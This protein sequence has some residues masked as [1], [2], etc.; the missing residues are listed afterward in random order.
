MLLGFSIIVLWLIMRTSRHI[1]STV[2]SRWIPASI[3]FIPLE[4]K[5]F[6][7]A[8]TQIRIDDSSSSKFIDGSLQELWPRSLDFLSWL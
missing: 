4:F 1:T 2:K 6:K 5:T 7:A 3:N 8:M